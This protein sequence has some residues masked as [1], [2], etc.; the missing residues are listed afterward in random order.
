MS[1]TPFIAM[2][3]VLWVLLTT[4]P[5]QGS[6]YFENRL[7]CD[8]SEDTVTVRIDTQ[9]QGTD[10]SYCFDILQRIA[11]KNQIL[12]ADLLRAQ[13]YSERWSSN[14]DKN[15]WNQ[16]VAAIQLDLLPYKTMK[17]LI[18]SAMRD[19]ETE[20]FISTKWLVSVYLKPEYESLS[21]KLSQALLLKERIVWLWNQQQFDF[22][23][24]KIEERETTLM[25]LR[26]IK[27]SS[28]FDTLIPP[29]KIYFS[30]KAPLDS[31]L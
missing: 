27:Q 16:V 25:V 28:S 15:Y 2:I 30:F 7:L 26:S 6:A 5:L 1:R 13:W 12:E 29:L 17:W 31:E 8:I 11:K 3:L 24:A 10:T 14:D 20:L 22:V 9:T 23:L 4:L 19:Y 18:V 21:E